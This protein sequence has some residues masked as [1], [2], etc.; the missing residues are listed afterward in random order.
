MVA[1]LLYMGCKNNDIYSYMAS[2]F[3]VTEEEA[4]NSI[5]EWLKFLIERGYV[6]DEY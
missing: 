4:K 6:K 2:Y 5:D 1:E 3:N